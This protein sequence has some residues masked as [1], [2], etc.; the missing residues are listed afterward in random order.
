MQ[1]SREE[2]KKRKEKSGR[3]GER[4]RGK[5]EAS[6]REEQREKGGERERQGNGGAVGPLEGVLGARRGLLGCS[7][8][9]IPSSAGAS[10]GALRSKTCSRL[11][12]A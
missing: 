5:K 12:L 6:E 4:G 11:S 10:W 7:W 9:H 3:D 8:Q 1:K 2:K